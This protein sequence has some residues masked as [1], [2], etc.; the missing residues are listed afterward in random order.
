MLLWV[1][2]WQRCLHQ[3]T[4]FEDSI[5]MIAVLLPLERSIPLANTGRRG[6]KRI[7]RGLGQRVAADALRLASMRIAMIPGHTSKRYE[8]IQD[9]V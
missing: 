1:N 8:T 5:R 2:A 4:S 6:T 9:L 3:N 7:E